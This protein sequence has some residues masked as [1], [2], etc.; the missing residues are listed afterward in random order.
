MHAAFSL[1]LFFLIESERERKKTEIVLALLLSVKNPVM[2]SWKKEEKTGEK[3][4]DFAQSRINILISY[5]P[6]VRVM[7]NTSSSTHT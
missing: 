1:A 4:D 3:N 2:M 7:S 6:T 5:D